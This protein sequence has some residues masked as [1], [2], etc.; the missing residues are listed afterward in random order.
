MEIL[1][2]ICLQL[3]VATFLRAGEIHSIIIENKGPLYILMV[4]TSQLAAAP[5]SGHHSLAHGI[6]L[7]VLCSL[8]TAPASHL[9]APS[10]ISSIPPRLTEFLL[11]PTSR[12]THIPSQEGFVR[13][14]LHF[15]PRVLHIPNLPHCLFLSL[16][17]PLFKALA[18][19]KSGL[20]ANQTPKN[21]AGTV[22]PNYLGI[23]RQSVVEGSF[24]S[25]LSL[26]LVLSTFSQQGLGLPLGT[27][28]TLTNGGILIGCHHRLDAFHTDKI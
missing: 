22:A 24:L 12:S 17:V 2:R 15:Y 7:R 8:L 21:V 14:P 23:L 10:S 20:G 4:P 16:W 11:A 19:S 28:S 27:L 13:G 26:P 18:R 25:L 6:F 3:G 9:I 5:P 1:R